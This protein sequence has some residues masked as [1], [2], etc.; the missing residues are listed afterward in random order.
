VTNPPYENHTRTVAISMDAEEKTGM[1]VAELQ[2]FIDECFK[3][4]VP[5]DQPV[6]IK[7]GW[8]QQILSITSG[9]TPG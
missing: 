8:R 4:G 3:S 1:T 9:R 5:A 6:K 2:H 7:T